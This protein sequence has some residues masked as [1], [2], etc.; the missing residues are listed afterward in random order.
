MMTDLPVTLVS[1]STA[2]IAKISM[3]QILATTIVEKFL[4]Y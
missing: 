1:S 4:Q 3:R 2:I